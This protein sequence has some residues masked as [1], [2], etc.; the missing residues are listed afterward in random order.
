MPR[1]MSVAFTED[2]VRNRTKTVTRRKG[3][4]FLKP[5]DRLTLCRKVM[6]RKPGEPLVRVAEVEVVEVWREPLGMVLPS[7]GRR[8]YG[9]A[10]MTREGFPGLEPAEFVRRYFTEAQGMTENDTV[11][12]I[13]WRFLDEPAA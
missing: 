9:E 7:W 5:G 13:E 3:W 1:L 6:G 2:A 12:R 4:T 11:T 8:K 10:E